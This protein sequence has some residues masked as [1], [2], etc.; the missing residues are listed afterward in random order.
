LDDIFIRENSIISSGM[1]DGSILWG[2]DIVDAL[3]K[4]H[5]ANSYKNMVSFF[6][7]NLYIK[8]G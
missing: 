2:K 8:K 6:L 3:K 5:D 1:P 4:K 7:N